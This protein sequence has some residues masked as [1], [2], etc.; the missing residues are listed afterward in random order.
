MVLSE[1][2]KVGTF[3]FNR[4]TKRKKKITQITDSPDANVH[5]V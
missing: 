1:S 2:V 3:I 5:Q 4:V